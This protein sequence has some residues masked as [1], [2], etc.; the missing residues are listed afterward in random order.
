MVVED[1]EGVQAVG[2]CKDQLK[3]RGGHRLQGEDAEEPVEGEEGQEDDTRPET[4]SNGVQVVAGCLLVVVLLLLLLLLLLMMMMMVIW[5]MLLLS[6]TVVVTAAVAVAVVVSLGR[7]DQQ[8]LPLK[9]PLQYEQHQQGVCLVFGKNI[10]NMMKMKAN[11]C[12]SFSLL[13][14][15]APALE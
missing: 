9:V 8:R 2:Q 4:G 5:M 13:P 14:K 7:L 10:K 6:V 3:G 11:F 15:S 1:E 12:S